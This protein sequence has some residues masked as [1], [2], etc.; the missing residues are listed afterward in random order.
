MTKAMT[1][2]VSDESRVPAGRALLTLI[3]V[4]TGFVMA[5][6]DL[7]V[8]NIA[9]PELRRSL[10]LSVEGLT[11]SIDGYMLTFASLLIVFGAVAARYGARR[12][13]LIG[14]SVF[15][16][17]SAVCAM[18]PSGSVL[19]AARIVQ[20][21]AAAAFIPASLVL[22]SH[23]FPDSAQRKQMVALWST[24]G[25]AASG[26]GP[27]I[28]GLLVSAFGWRSIFY[29]NLPVGLLGLLLSAIFVTGAAPTSKNPIGYAKHASLLIAAAGLSF[30]LITGPGHGWTSPSVIASAIVA[31]VFAVLFAWQDAHALD[32]TWPP[33]LLRRRGFVAM[34]IVGLGLNFGLY[35]VLYIIGLLLQEEFDLTPVAAGLHLLPIMIVFVVANLTFSKF[36][37]D[38]G[39]R[40]PVLIGLT[41]ASIACI[42]VWSVGGSIGLL[43]LTVTM[44]VANIGLGTTAPAM[45]VGLMESAGPEYAPIASS[46][47]NATRQFGTLLGVAAAGSIIASASSL[48]TALQIMLILSCSSY[49]LSGV[50]VV[51]LLFKSTKETTQP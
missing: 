49:V 13:Y 47:F 32:R 8:I 11:W 10:S 38:V 28:G 23:A 29:L 35:G 27:V 51:A 14:L 18:A 34:T 21:S 19:I 46:T 15:V 41:V 12:V 40:W 42:P 16:A 20:G 1:T 7:T 48:H 6:L 39:T 5:A 2:A 43:A 36:V 9:G 25:A 26:I 37:A 44:M 50:L 30:L 17:T 31:I 33:D 3:A 22:L 24:A 4:A 45:T